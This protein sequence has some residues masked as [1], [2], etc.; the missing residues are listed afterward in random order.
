MVTSGDQVQRAKILGT[1]PYL[2]E[3]NKQLNQNS[4]HNNQQSMTSLNFNK[5][6]K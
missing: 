1:N 2:L 3:I 5:A 4:A 6:S